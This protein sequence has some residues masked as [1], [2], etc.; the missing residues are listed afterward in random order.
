MRRLFAL[1]GALMGALLLASPA[2]AN[3]PSLSAAPNVAAVAAALRVTPVYVDPGLR[4]TVSAADIGRLL[5]V[6]PSGVHI[7]VLPKSVIPAGADPTELPALISAGVGQ[8]GTF[9]ILIDGRLYGAS[10]TIPG[11]LADNLATTQ[12]VL[13]KSGD[14]TPALIALARSLTGPSDLQDNTSPSRAGGPI[15]VALLVVIAGVAV[16]GGLGLWWWLRRKPKTH[17]RRRV[18]PPRDLVEIDFEGNVVS[19]T[20]GAERHQ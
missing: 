10:T 9:I 1:A 5:P 17:R 16:F 15:G 11:Q 14:V 13:P 3:A 6:L 4:S 19:R 20:P 7:A 2:S 12:A 18:E 8:G